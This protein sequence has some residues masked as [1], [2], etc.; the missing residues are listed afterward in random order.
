M[1]KEVATNFK[2]YN[3]TCTNAN[4]DY[5]VTLEKCKKFYIGLQS[6]VLSIIWSLGVDGVYFNFTGTE[7]YEEND[8]YLNS[9]T[10]TVKASIAGEVIQVLAWS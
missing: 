7:V 2:I 6:K 1:S 10:I 4:T 3:I 8:I 5:T 9:R